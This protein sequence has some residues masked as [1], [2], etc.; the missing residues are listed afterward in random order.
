MVL[1]RKA[2]RCPKLSVV[3]KII[4]GLGAYFVRINRLQKISILIKPETVLGFHKALVAR[5]YR[6]LFSSQP[7]RKPGPKGPSAELIR[8]VVDLK[9]KNPYYGCEKI[10]LLICNSFGLQVNEQRVRRILR[11]YLKPPPS[12]GPS[13]LSFLGSAKD[14]LWSVDFFRCESI[15]LQSYAVMIV[16]DQFTRKIMGVAVCCY[17]AKGED[18]CRMFA[19]VVSGAKSSPRHLSFDHDPL[20]GFSQWKANLRVLEIDSIQ[21]VPD[22]PWSHP[23]VERLIG[24]VRRE[25]LDQTLF[26]NEQDLER[27][28]REYASYYNEARVH[29]SISATP[30]QKFKNL[31]LTPLEL[32][33]YRWISHC[34]GLFQT[35]VAA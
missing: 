17:P 32:N 24:S 25:C 11:K 8:L 13:W 18:A 31:D 21:T 23:F 20:F 9:I 26:W 19:G 14:S 30:V 4:F 34:R 5:K 33:Q 35:P 6:L 22:I 10:V 2:G 1:K 15:L 12:S 16:L 3:D 7:K 29:L 28:L 27:K